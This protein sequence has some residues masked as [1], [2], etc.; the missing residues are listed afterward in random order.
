MQAVLPGLNVCKKVD[1]ALH[2]FVVRW[3][4]HAIA[5]TIKIYIRPSGGRGNETSGMESA[6]L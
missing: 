2:R 1:E 4:S 5:G 3:R 6:D